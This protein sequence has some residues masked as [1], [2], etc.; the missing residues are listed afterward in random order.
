LGASLAR[1]EAT[2]AIP[3]LVR[4]FPALSP[5]YDE[6]AWSQRTALRGLDVMPVS[7]T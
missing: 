6:P 2:V 4:R 1:I 7:L 3:S 5:A